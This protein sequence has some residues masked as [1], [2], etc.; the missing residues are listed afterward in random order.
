LEGLSYHLSLALLIT[1]LAALSLALL[2]WVAAQAKR[3]LED[4]GAQA[5]TDILGAAQS[6]PRPSHK[7]LELLI[8]MFVWMVSDERFG[9]L[10]RDLPEEVINRIVDALP[11]PREEPYPG[12]AI[13]DEMLRRHNITPWP[14]PAAADWPAPG[15]LDLCL[16][17]TSC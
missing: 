5:V 2:N 8:K 6:R 14:S 9:R 4:H 11:A 16:R 7:R 12:Q 1:L 17:S 13:W 10:L 3:L 15:L